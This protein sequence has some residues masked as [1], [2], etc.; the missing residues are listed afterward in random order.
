MLK[1]IYTFFMGILLA[2]FVGVGITAF[3]S[4]PEY[5]DCQQYITTPF[6]SPG[7][8]SS[9]ES[10]ITPVSGTEVKTSDECRAAQD[11]YNDASKVHSRN[12]STVALAAAILFLVIGLVFAKPLDLLADGFL[13]GG[14]FTL[15]YAVAN[16]FMTDDYK[17]QFII[18]TVG[19]IIALVLGYIKFVRSAE[20]KRS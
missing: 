6:A 15:L 12:A 13:L 18:V 14:V 3:Y 8:P 7:G 10:G 19:L 17:Y 2:T 5:P 20:K 4:A 1:I 9:S 11:A 16:G